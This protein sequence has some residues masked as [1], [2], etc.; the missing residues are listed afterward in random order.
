MT[1]N[2]SSRSRRVPTRRAA[3][4]ASR[5]TAHPRPR[6]SSIV[7]GV[8][9]TNLRTGVAA[10]TFN[11]RLHRRSPGQVVRPCRRIRRRDRRRDQRDFAQRHEPVFRRSVGTYFNNA[12]M[13]GNLALNNTAGTRRRVSRQ[14]LSPVASGT[15]SRV[16]APPE[17]REP[18]RDGGIQQGRLLA[19]GSCLPAGRSDHQGQACGSGAATRRIMD[20]T[21]PHR[22]LPQQWLD[23][24]VHLQRDDADLCSATS[25]GRWRNQCA[26]AS[27]FR[28]V[29]SRRKAA[30]R[31]PNGTSNPLTSFRDAWH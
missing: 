26:C 27:R 21:R 24:Y 3:A 13:N 2:R 18:G 4:A 25:P 9:T 16:T 17:R 31:L 28:I 11:Y 12:S 10:T 15:T 7:D 30:C 29:H 8:D 19:L 20:E 6:T 5:L 1:F 22:H 14:R 23:G